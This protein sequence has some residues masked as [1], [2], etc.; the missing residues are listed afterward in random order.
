VDNEPVELLD[1]AERVC[2]LVRVL[3]SIQW[4]LSD[5]TRM[6]QGGEPDAR[7][8]VLADLWTQLGVTEPSYA[9]ADRRA[10]MLYAAVKAQAQLVQD[11]VRAVLLAALAEMERLAEAGASDDAH[12][13]LGLWDFG[14]AGLLRT[15]E[16]VLVG[17]VDAL[18]AGHPGLGL[19][20]EADLLAVNNGKVL[21]LAG[22][23]GQKLFR[24]QRVRELTLSFSR[25]QRRDR[26]ER[27]RRAREEERLLGERYEQTSAG[28]LRAAV[29]A[30]VAQLRGRL[31]SLEA[32]RGNGTP[33]GG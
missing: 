18:P 16:G 9:A 26:E 11:A 22:V 14:P 30:E 27:E 25:E 8:A 20:D 10:E 4:T 13:F 31:A 32:A 28:R 24:A 21:V 7:L 17:R 19:V 6:P 33:P 1:W 12:P 29:E 3:E 23:R 15:P 2:D 5:L